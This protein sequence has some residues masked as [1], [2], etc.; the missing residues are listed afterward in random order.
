MVNFTLINVVSDSAGGQIQPHHPSYQL[1][2]LAKRLHVPNFCVVPIT[3]T[4]FSERVY[5]RLNIRVTYNESWYYKMTDYKPT[6]AYLFPEIVNGKAYAFWGVYF[7]LHYTV[8]GIN[9]C[10]HAQY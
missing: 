8:E 6:L 2:Q 1:A 7:V 5:S 4:E 3:F 10:I 9:S